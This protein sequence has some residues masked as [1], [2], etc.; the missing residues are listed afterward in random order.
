MHQNI[1]WAVRGL[2][3]TA[4]AAAAKSLQ[5]SPTLCNP[6]EGSPPG[7]PVPGILQA[8]TLEWLAISLSGSEVWVPANFM[9]WKPNP[10]HDR[11]W[12]WVLHALTCGITVAI[13]EGL[14]SAI[15]FSITWGRCEST[16]HESGREL[17][18]RGPCYSLVCGRPASR[19]V[20]TEFLLFI[21]PWVGDTFCLITPQAD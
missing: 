8:K 20:S 17:S 3:F 15:D 11:L 19:T 1:S 14:Q 10:K 16:S 6:I 7:S 4:A 21:I 2:K 9:L 13:R 18:Q 5:L 12:R